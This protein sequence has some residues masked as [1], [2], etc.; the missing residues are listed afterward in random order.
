MIKNIKPWE[1]GE[2]INK[3]NKN[4]IPSLC[5]AD[6]ILV[7]LAPPKKT[8]SVRDGLVSTHLMRSYTEIETGIKVE[9]IKIAEGEN[10]PVISF[11]KGKSGLIATKFRGPKN[12]YRYI[13]S[14]TG[15]PY[16]IPKEKYTVEYAIKY[17]K[18]EIPGMSGIPD[19]DSLT[20]I[21]KDALID[22][23]LYDMFTAYGLGLDLIL[24]IK[25][26]T[27]TDLRVGLQTELYRTYTPPQGESK[28]PDIIIT[29]WLKGQPSLSGE[30]T[31]LP[32]ELALKTYEEYLKRDDDTKFDPEALNDEDE[33]VI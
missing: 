1:L 7:K 3:E 25:D 8:N 15:K 12:W 29:K 23:Y 17:L 32:E 19:F 21:E 30:Y 16:E 26:G 31:L 22:E 28:W 18:G 9:T 2:E 13:N 5:K 20:D 6:Y 14:E 27:L 24:P 10:G 33:D 11:P 4:N